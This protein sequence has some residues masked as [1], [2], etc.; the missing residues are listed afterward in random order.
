MQ[1][2]LFTELV[3]VEYSNSVNSVLYIHREQHTVHIMQNIL[4]T[5][6]VFAEC[7]VFFTELVYAEYID[8]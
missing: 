8:C 7:T 5:E 3:H 2:I 1:S 6:L 4:F